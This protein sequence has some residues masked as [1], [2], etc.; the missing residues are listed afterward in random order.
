MTRVAYAVLALALLATPAGAH[1][2]YPWSC[3]NARDCWLMDP[4]EYTLDERG[5]VIHATGE[6]FTD[7]E[8][9]R[10]APDGGVHRC[11][12]HGDRNAPTIRVGNSPCAWA[13]W[14]GF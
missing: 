5:L 13:P 9:R 12:R 8:V 10:D 2:W 6:V 3:C 14:G 7:E 11:S 1:S 4:S